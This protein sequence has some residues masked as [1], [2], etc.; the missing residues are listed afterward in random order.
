MDKRPS[1]PEAFYY[2]KKLLVM[3]KFIGVLIIVIVLITCQPE[4][5]VFVEHKKLSPNVEWLKKDSRAFKVPINDTSLLY[6][7]SLSFRFA[8]GYRYQVAMVKVTET[9]PSGEQV[10]NE[11]SLKVR[12]ENGDYIGEPGFDIWDSEHLVEPGKKYHEK[13]TYSYL[14]EQNTPNDPLNYAMEIGVI[15]DKVN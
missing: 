14:I 8:N 1:I 6:D 3:R 4:G 2:I 15:L 10:T 7:L 11:Y 5:R 9:S 12:E 13:G